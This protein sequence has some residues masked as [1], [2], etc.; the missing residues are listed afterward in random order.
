FRLTSCGQFSAVNRRLFSFFV[1]GAL[2]S[3]MVYGIM[4]QE[5]WFSLKRNSVNDWLM[6]LFHYP[7]LSVMPQ[8]L[9]FRTYFYHRYNRI[10]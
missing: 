9:F 7:S 2:F 5:H 10:M 6:L 1:V 8:E 4:N 3:G